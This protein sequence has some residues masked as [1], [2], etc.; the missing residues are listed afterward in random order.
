MKVTCNMK[1]GINNIL[2]LNIKENHIMYID[3]HELCVSCMK[4]ICNLFG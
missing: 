1:L 4:L 3:T 2:T